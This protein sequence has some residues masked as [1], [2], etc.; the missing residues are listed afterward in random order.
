M[1]QTSARGLRQRAPLQLR[2][3]ALQQ[4]PKACC[5]KVYY[6]ALERVRFAKKTDVL[7]DVRIRKTDVL[8]DVRF[9]KM[10]S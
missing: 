8:K 5:V 9:E 6:A 1:T 4:L 10:T 2:R 3:L 7:E